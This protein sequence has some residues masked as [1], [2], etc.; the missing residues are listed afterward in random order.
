MIVHV[1][2]YA[3][4]AVLIV[5][6]VRAVLAVCLN[7]LFCSHLPRDPVCVGDGTTHRVI[8]PGD[9]IY[10]FEGDWKGNCLVIRLNVTILVLT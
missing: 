2:E 9:A 1:R 3:V 6:A 8:I 4:L 7:S 5:P 10:D